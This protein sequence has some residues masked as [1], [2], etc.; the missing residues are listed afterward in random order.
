MS[1]TSICVPLQHYL[2]T[3]Y[4]PDRDYVDGRLEKRHVGEWSHAELQAALVQYLRTNAER[5]RARTVQEIRVRVSPTRYRV[6]DVCCVRRAPDDSG[7]ITEPPVLV[8]EILSPDDIVSQTEDRTQDYLAR[9]VP[10]VWLID[11]RNLDRTWIYEPDQ[12]Q[13]VCDRIL[14]AGEIRVP[15]NELP[16]QRDFE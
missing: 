10:F 7:I 8:I 13:R 9:G 1:T 11:P 5:F 14:S 3:V 2:N 16:E 15:L 4:R 6:A 12:R